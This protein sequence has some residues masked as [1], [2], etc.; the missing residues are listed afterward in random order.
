[1]T[2]SLPSATA[3][4]HAPGP[5]ATALIC[6]ALLAVFATL[7]LLS[8]RSKSPT[9]DEPLHA[10]AAY[11]LRER[12]FGAVDAGSANHRLDW[13]IFCARKTHHKSQWRGGAEA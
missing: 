7:A 12:R 1:M 13:W 9:Y 6:A 10:L 3:S 8:S 5:R 2:V 4:A 11:Q